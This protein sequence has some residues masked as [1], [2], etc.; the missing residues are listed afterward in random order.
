VGVLVLL[1]ITGLWLA[2]RSPA[3]QIQGMVDADS[4]N[5]AAKV[6]ARLQ[7]VSV[8]EGARVQAGQVL[9]VLDSPEVAAKE[10]QADA[11]VAA[12]TAQAEKADN[13]ARS[14]EIAMARSEWERAQAGADVAAATFRR[15][16]NLLAEGVV[17]RQKHDEA[18]AQRDSAQALARAARA[19]YDLAQAGARNEDRQA[20]RAQ[21]AQAEGARDEVQAAR[22]ETTGMAPRAGE[23]GKRLADVGEIVAAGYP[24]FTLVDI[25]NPWVAFHLREDQLDG[26]QIGDTVRGTLPALQGG[27]VE[28]TVYFLSPAGDYATWRSTR[29]SSGYDV[30]SFE[31]RA[32]PTRAV[33][34]LR[35][36]MSVLLPWPQH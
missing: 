36:G 3:D 20:A 19:Q 28:L 35:P 17:T 26:L 34:G 12:A 33:P 4:L 22:A 9:F 32:R 29:Q 15:V 8:E 10:R 2:W 11:L 5:V 18:R 13:G 14:Q 23:V 21:V 7:S 6:T 16:D 31:V 1:A 25:D 24:V 30:R 27:E